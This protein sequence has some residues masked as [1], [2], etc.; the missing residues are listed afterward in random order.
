MVTWL[1]VAAILKER[2]LEASTYGLV[3]Q[4][5]WLITVLIPKTAE[6]AGLI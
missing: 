2:W 3:K 6:T 5:T 1:F 4:G